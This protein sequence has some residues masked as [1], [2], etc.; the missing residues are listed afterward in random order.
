MYVWQWA[1]ALQVCGSSSVLCRALV[2]GG[3]EHE[4]LLLFSLP[5]NFSQQLL[6][7]LN[8]CWRQLVIV[9]VW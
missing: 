6:L 3:A 8:G 9:Q 5:G 7:K 4:H 1:A 2:M